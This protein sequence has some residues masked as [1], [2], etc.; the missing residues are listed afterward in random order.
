MRVQVILLLALVLTL[1][2]TSGYT[3]SAVSEGLLSVKGTW[4]VNSIGRVVL[5]RGVNYPGYEREQTSELHSESA[6]ELCARAGFNVVRLPIA[7]SSLESVPGMFDESYLASY[8]DQDIR[9]AKKYGL[10]VVLDMHQDNRASKFGGNGAPDWTVNQYPSTDEGI[11]RA[12]SDFWNQTNLQDHLVKVWRN[13][14]RRYANESTIAGYDILNE[15][16]IYTSINPDLDASN[17]NDFY[18]RAIK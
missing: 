16:W 15:P 9:W 3:A 17:V 13:I 18:V 5:L 2:L 14:A 1:S 6:Y 10:Y 4:I 8:V 12:V 7:W 11:R